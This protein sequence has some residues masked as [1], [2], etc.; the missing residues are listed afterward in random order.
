MS[1]DLDFTIAKLELKPGDIVVLKF[2]Q[3]LSHEQ[4]MHVREYWKT[5]CPSVKALILESGAEITLLTKA[6]LE[7]QLGEEEPA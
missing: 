4:M 2:P 1:I 6:E 7:R 5:I 3:R